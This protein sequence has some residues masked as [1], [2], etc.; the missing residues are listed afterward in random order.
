MYE[1]RWGPQLYVGEKTMEFY[2]DLCAVAMEEHERLQYKAVVFFLS[3][4]L[5]FICTDSEVF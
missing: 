3:T 4:H 2:P 1:Y 5:W